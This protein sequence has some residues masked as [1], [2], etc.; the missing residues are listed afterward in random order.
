MS[1][2][3][4]QAYP[5]AAEYDL[6]TEGADVQ[7]MYSVYQEG[8]Y[9]GYRYFETRYEDVVMGTEM[10]IRDSGRVEEVHFQC[11]GAVD[12]DDD[13]LE[14]AVVLQCLQV[15]QQLDL[16]GGPALFSGADRPC[17]VRRCLCPALLPRVAG[18]PVSYTHLLMI[19]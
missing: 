18:G 19:L 5:N 14:G 13:G 10:C 3:Y 9:L 16:L 1:N 2:F 11:V 15:L 7:G 6:L 8:I 4:T 12:Q 17:M